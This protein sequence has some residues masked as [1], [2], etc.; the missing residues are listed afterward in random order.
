MSRLQAAGIGFTGW[1]WRQNTTNTD[2]YAIVEKDPVGGADVVKTAVLAVYSKYW[3][4]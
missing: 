1:Q 3:K 2:E 4:A